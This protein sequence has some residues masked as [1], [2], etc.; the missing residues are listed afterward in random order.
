[1]RQRSSRRF[2]PTVLTIVITLLILGGTTAGAYPMT[3]AWFSSYNQSKIVEAFSDDVKSAVPSASQQLDQARRYNEALVAGVKLDR[4]ANVPVG[5]GSSQVKGLEYDRL[6]SANAEGVMGRIKIDS[7][8]V[9]LPIYHGTSDAVLGRGA[10]H[11]EGSSLPVGGKGT[12]SVITA[13]RGLAN[14]TMFTHLDRVKEGDQFTL[15]VFGEVLVYQVI[16][17]QVI[18]PEDTATLRAEPNQDLVSLITC[19]PLGI[20]TQ[21]IVVTGKRITPTP[22]AAQAALGQVPT[23]PGFPWWMVILGAGGALAIAYFVLQGRKD[24]RIRNRRD[25]AHLHHAASQPHPA[26]NQL[27]LLTRDFAR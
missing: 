4:N 23:I 7:A 20:N 9:D 6:L 1:M 13:H 17:T 10:G 12:R 5:T 21:R 2:R 27:P 16:K 18:D 24:A 15:E 3:A 22:P 26:D 19:T 25:A 8:E 14:A 11:L